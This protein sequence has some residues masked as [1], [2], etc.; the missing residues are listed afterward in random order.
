MDQILDKDAIIILFQNYSPINSNEE[1]RR[2][3]LDRQLNYF[4]HHNKSDK[5]ILLSIGDLFDTLMWNNQ[6]ALID[7]T[8]LPNKE[9]SNLIAGALFEIVRPYIY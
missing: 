5:V 9:G 6:F 4:H 2:K 8:G 1:A 7:D 3:E